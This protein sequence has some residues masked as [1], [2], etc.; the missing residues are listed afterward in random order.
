[1]TRSVG[2]LAALTTPSTTL[3]PSSPPA[4]SSTP[5]LPWTFLGGTLP[6]TVAWAGCR[7]FA[8]PSTTQN[9]W[10]VTMLDE[11]LDLKQNLDLLSQWWEI[12][13][14]LM[15][16]QQGLTWKPSFLIFKWVLQL[17]P[18][19]LLCSLEKQEKRSFFFEIVPS[20]PLFKKK[21]KHNKTSKVTWQLQEC[22]LA[23][24]FSTFF[25]VPQKSITLFKKRK[26][27]AKGWGA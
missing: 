1:M 13:I 22:S 15:T 8:Q 4:G 14:E 2:W 20:V 11:M 25:G 18:I 9:G 7:H 17:L 21:K 24:S 27:A 26:S 19:I 3:L 10:T 16:F 5:P 23:P 6:F 12:S